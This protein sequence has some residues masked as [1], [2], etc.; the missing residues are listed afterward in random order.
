MIVGQESPVELTVFAFDVDDISGNGLTYNWTWNGG[1]LP[2]GGQGG[3]AATCSFQ[4]LP[5]YMNNMRVVITVSDEHG[6]ETSRFLDLEIWNDVVATASST[7]GVSVAYS[8]QYFSTTPFTITSEDVSENDM[9]DYTGVSLPGFSGVYDAVAAIDFEPSNSYD[10]TAVLSQ[11]LE[12]TVPKSMEA[13]S[14][15]SYTHLT[16]PT[17]A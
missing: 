12:V 6:S 7:S 14:T 4:I 3:A 8:V 5:D 17:K 10:G 13:T 15:V 9:A 16:L 2:C 11:S 1:L